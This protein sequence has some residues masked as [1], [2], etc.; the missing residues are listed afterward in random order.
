[1]ADRLTSFRGA[2]AVSPRRTPGRR[3]R[4][5]AGR[6]EDVA[7]A[8]SALPL[9]RKRP[10]P[11]GGRSPWALAASRQPGAPRPLPSFRSS[12]RGGLDFS[13]RGPCASW[14][15]EAWRQQQQRTL[16]SQ[17]YLRLHENRPAEVDRRQ[18]TPS[19]MPS[20]RASATPWRRSTR[21]RDPGST[22]RP[23]P[24]CRARATR[25]GRRAPGIAREP[26]ETGARGASLGLSAVASGWWE[27][28]QPTRRE[29]REPA[30]PSGLGACHRA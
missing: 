28:V 23:P 7:R 6:A 25:G 21:R 27:G 26:R 15:S 16:P 19:R 14:I 30:T 8:L 29:H 10:I 12:A 18:R 2:S 22:C 24:Q 11:D 17:A 20:W 5:R 3:D 1:M 13:T 9:P 4:A